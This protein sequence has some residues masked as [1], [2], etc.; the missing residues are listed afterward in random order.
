MINLPREVHDS[1]VCI[2]HAYLYVCIL[3]LVVIEP[4]CVAQRCV[5][6]HCANS[7]SATYGYSRGKP[8]LHRLSMSTNAD[9]IGGPRVA[10]SCKNISSDSLHS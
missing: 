10:V 1:V 8:P 5:F 7:E 3:W 4:I 9:S 6:L 2:A